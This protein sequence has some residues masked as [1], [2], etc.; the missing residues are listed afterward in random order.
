MPLY[1]SSSDP[2][3]ALVREFC[4]RLRKLGLDDPIATLGNVSAN[5]ANVTP[6]P[7]RESP[8]AFPQAGG[9]GTPTNCDA[10]PKPTLTV[11][12]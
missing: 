6:P 8:M 4:A 5:V 2:I 7:G 10:N 11:D 9:Q 3:P 12:R 1:Q